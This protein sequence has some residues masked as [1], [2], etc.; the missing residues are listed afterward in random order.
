M[1]TSSF[2]VK[3]D[4]PAPLLAP[5]TDLARNPFNAFFYTRLAFLLDMQRVTLKYINPGI[6]TCDFFLESSN[7]GIRS[8]WYTL[9]A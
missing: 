8:G 3:S 9:G 5:F 7:P 4:I 6:L 2:C 1:S